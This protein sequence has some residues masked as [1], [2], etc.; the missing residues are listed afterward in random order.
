MGLP[1]LFLT[2]TRG[3]R[4]PPGGV[5]AGGPCPLRFFNGHRPRPTEPTVVPGPTSFSGKTRPRAEA[6]VGWDVPG[7][8][9]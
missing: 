4:K 1:V 3:A 2:T 8:G 7:G 5:F 6:F 9:F